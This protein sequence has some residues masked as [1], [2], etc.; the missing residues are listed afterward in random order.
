MDFSQYTIEDF[1]QKDAFIAWVKTGEGND[2]WQNVLKNYPHQLQTI[3]QAKAFIQAANTLPV[4]TLSDSAKADMWQRIDWRIEEDETLEKPAKSYRLWWA[5]AA[6]VAVLTVINVLY[7]YKNDKNTVKIAQNTYGTS[8]DTREGGTLSENKLTTQSNSANV[9]TFSNDQDKPRLI[10]LPDGSSISLHK[11]SQF[12]YHSDKFNVENREI[13][14][15]GEAFFDIAKNPKKPF[16][17][18]A[19]DLVTKVLGTSF[20]II[21][22]PKDKKVVV[23]VRSGKVSV[24]NKNDIVLSDNAISTKTAGIILTP[25]Q[26]VIFTKETAKMVKTLVEVPIIIVQ[27]SIVQ[28]DFNFVQTSVSKAFGI[29]EQ[30]YGVKIS[31]DEKILRGCTITAPLED[32]TLYEKLDI[33]CKITRSS[34]EVLDGQIVVNSR[35]CK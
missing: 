7:F 16:L 8:R 28:H 19:N 18:Y 26:Q 29:L 11:N 15:T 2:F 4:A 3:A 1:V 22:L 12:Y 17:I 6:S 10:N 21:A 24:F 34:Y 32:E 27:S 13:Y 31:Y 5:A 30:A 23:S 9:I 20:T 33:I 35:G 14:F 25:N